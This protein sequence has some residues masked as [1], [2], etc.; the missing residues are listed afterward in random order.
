M[1][2][3]EFHNSLQEMS[4]SFNSK[5]QVAHL[6]LTIRMLGNS[7]FHKVQMWRSPN[8]S[9][10]LRDSDSG[11]MERDVRILQIISPIQITTAQMF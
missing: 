5:R 3:L 8:S 10:D 9:L 4:E 2:D 6:V 11:G 7:R 1:E